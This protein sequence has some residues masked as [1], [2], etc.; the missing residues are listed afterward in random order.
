M[1]I[2]VSTTKKAVEIKKKIITKLIMLDVRG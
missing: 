2:Y 1:F